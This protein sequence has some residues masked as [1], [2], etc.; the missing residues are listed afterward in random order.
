MVIQ[1]KERHLHEQ[2]ETGIVLLDD[3]IDYLQHVIKGFLPEV[4]SQFVIDPSDLSFVQ[5]RQI[6]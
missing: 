3:F 1:K 4:V 2:R 6:A 5:L